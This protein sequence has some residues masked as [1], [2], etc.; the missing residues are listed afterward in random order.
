MDT[1]VPRAEDARKARARTVV[2][3]CRILQRPCHSPATALPQPCQG[4]ATALPRPCH[5]P[6]TALPQPCYSPASGRVQPRRTGPAQRHFSGA[7]YAFILIDIYI[8]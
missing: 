7:K 6:A 5:C 4:T 2:G 1:R 3:V 8:Y